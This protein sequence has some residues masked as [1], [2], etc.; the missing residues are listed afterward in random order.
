M[1]YVCLS[2][3]CPT[4]GT[5]QFLAQNPELWST[6]DQ[7]IQYLCGW[8]NVYI[9]IVMYSEYIPVPL[10]QSL[11]ATESA[12]LPQFVLTLPSSSRQSTLL[13]PDAHDLPFSDQ[14]WSF[15]LKS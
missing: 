2:F 8:K 7:R 1:Y 11:E 12:A 15:K 6:V 5:P 3:R 4:L 13:D 10:A 14:I 9:I